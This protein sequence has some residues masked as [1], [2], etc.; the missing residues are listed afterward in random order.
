LDAA[1]GCL[2]FRNENLFAPN[3]GISGIPCGTTLLS[4]AC[5]NDILFVG[6]VVATEIEEECLNLE[7][8][9]VTAMNLESGQVSWRDVLFWEGV[10]M[11]GPE[12]C[13]ESGTVI[14]GTASDLAAGCLITWK[15]STGQRIS[16]IKFHHRVHSMTLA[17][18]LAALVLD[19]REHSYGIL[20]REDAS[21][22]EKAKEVY[23]IVVRSAH[24]EL[25][26]LRTPPNGYVCSLWLTVEGLLC[27]VNYTGDVHLLD[28]STG[29]VVLQ[30]SIGSKGFWQIVLH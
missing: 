12:Y 2:K 13:K 24:A 14:A 6:F 27:W 11:S 29:T 21:E 4:I 18:G 23:D 5:S 9:H 26:R 28:I 15:A 19:P 20:L 17:H 10:E 25:F 22:A 3:P 16:C 30:T 7:F 8:P 1:T